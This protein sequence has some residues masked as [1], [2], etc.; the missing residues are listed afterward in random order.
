MHLPL[1]QLPVPPKQRL[2]VDIIP[3]ELPQVLEHQRTQPVAEVF[4]LSKLGFVS[5]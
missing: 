5:N 3:E 1:K 4:E 2:P